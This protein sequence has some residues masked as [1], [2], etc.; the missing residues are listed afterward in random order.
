MGRDTTA[1]LAMW[2]AKVCPK[3]CDWDHKPKLRAKFNL[4]NEGYF[5]KVPG[6]NLKM[7]Y[8]VWS[9]IHYGYVGRA[10]GIDRDTLID[11]A[12]VSDPLLV[13]EDDNGDHITMQA[14]IDLYDKYGLNLTREQFHEAVISTAELLYS[15]GSDQAQY[16]P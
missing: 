2:A 8:G 14:G 16:A 12:S 3:I 10:A 1:A 11:G 4:D 9:N 7:F 5:Q 15:Q 6:R 13:G